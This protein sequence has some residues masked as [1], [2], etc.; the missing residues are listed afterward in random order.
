MLGLR[1]GAPM[2]KML[3]D[4]LTSFDVEGYGDY[5]FCPFAPKEAGVMQI[6]CVAK[7][8]NY[9]VRDRKQ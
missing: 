1:D 6:G 5:E 2:P 7:V 9:Q 3:E 4:T 8:S